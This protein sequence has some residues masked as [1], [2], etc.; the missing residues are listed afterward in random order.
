VEVVIQKAVA[1][2]RA[3]CPHG[4]V[5]VR[6]D[7][8][9]VPAVLA[10]QVHSGA[11]ETNCAPLFLRRLGACGADRQRHCKRVLFGRFQG[12]ALV[13]ADGLRGRRQPGV[14]AAVS[15]PRRR[16]RRA[17]RVRQHH[18]CTVDSR[19]FAGVSPGCYWPRRPSK[20]V[21]RQWNGIRSNR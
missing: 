19:L 4:S 20:C 11:G 1:R 9:R 17:L 5:R 13:E 2:F 21:C 8:C 14:Q 10:I 3:V 7:D 18:A 12:P 15:G 16:P 6:P